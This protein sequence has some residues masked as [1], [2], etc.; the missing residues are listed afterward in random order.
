MP[1]QPS[2]IGPSSVAAGAHGRAPRG[3]SLV[4]YR[5]EMIGLLWVA[6]FL[7]QAD[8]A[9]YNVVLPKLKLDLSLSDEQLGLVV[10]IF[11][12]TYG[13][14]VPIA[15]YAGDVL[16][17][18]WIICGSLFF[19]SM[20]TVFTGVSNSLVQLMVFR[21]VST[22]GGEAFYYP[23]ANSLIAQIHHKTRALAMGIHQTANY[24]GIIA[25][26]LIA[27]YIADR[28]GWREAFYVFGGAGIVWSVLLLVR[29]KH[30]P[31]PGEQ[32]PGDSAEHD[33]RASHG[34]LSAPAERI[35]LAVVLREVF[36]KPTVWA[37]CLSFGGHQF[38]GIAYLTWMPT[39]LHEKFDLTLTNAG[40]SSMFYHHA[41]AML[42]VLLG[43]R[44]SDLW[45]RNR[46]T[47]R[48]ET[49]AAGLLLGA[50][51]VALMGLA[52]NLW[53][54]YAGLAL[55][56]LFRGV[57]DSN[58]FAAQFDVIAP[59]LRSSSVGIMLAF[60]FL[61]GALGPYLLP[62]VKSRYDMSTAIAALSAVYF[63]AGVVMLAA[64]FLFFPRDYVRETPAESA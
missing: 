38:V 63:G 11:T 2:T 46:Y 12:W 20:T 64:R 9:V 31:P 17:R 16:R 26:G 14:L 1:D 5:W 52:T 57:Y 55:F 47:A 50:P 33:A 51:F 43:G 28:W 27:G 54:C 25:S 61:V 3:S 34:A 56:G 39:F 13:V 4:P 24:T 30:T 29:L 18:K 35:P 41:A 48:M 15:G 37:L 6:F 10:L 32:S 23:A 53:V 36:R 19:W 40:F 8:R 59:R 45:S 62:F 21:G 58:L 44:L 49:E 60:G 42:G 7:N 22:G